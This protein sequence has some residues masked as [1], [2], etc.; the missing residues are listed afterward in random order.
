MCKGKG[1]VSCENQF[2]LLVD[3]ATALS[4]HVHTRQ[5]AWA[6]KAAAFQTTR[7]NFS[8][9][10]EDPTA[11]LKRDSRSWLYSTPVFSRTHSSVMTTMTT[12]RSAAADCRSGGRCASYRNILWCLGKNGIFHNCQYFTDYKMS[13]ITQRQ[14]FC[15]KGR[16]SC[17]VWCKPCWHEH[18][19][20]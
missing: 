5:R 10:K 14:T 11:A 9:R 8:T 2:M 3:W 16:W 17:E 19:N 4:S 6:A 18:A 1:T 7:A 13:K 20:S 12:W 15:E